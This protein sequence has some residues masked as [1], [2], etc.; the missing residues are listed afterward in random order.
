M[1]KPE[2]LWSGHPPNLD[3]LRV[4][5]CVAYAHIRQDKT[6]PRALRY[7]FMGYLK[8]VKASR[9]RYVEPGHKVKM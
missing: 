5:G 1:K 9:L 4:F 2:E 7:M 8:G 3:R 6:E